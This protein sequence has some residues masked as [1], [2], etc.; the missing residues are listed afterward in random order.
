MLHFR[1]SSSPSTPISPRR[2]DSLAVYL[3]LPPLFSCSYKLLFPQLFSIDTL[4]KTGVCP[5]PTSLFCSFHTLF[6]PRAF[7]ISCSFNCFRTLSKNCR[8][9]WVFLTKILSRNSRS[10]CS[11][12]P[13]SFTPG[14]SGPRQS[15]TLLLHV[16]LPPGQSSFSRRPSH[17]SSTAYKMLLPQVF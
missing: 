5:T 15:Q 10:S 4:A 12:T 13:C 16:C 8:V 17:F 11:G 9:A 6:S 1:M 3:A 14:L 7:H 2:N